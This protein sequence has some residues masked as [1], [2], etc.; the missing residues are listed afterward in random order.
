MIGIDII[1][2]KRIKKLIK[3]RKFIER[4]FSKEEIEYCENKKNKEQHYSAR[5][6]AKEA[7]WKALA[8]KYSVPLKNIVIKNIQNGK[9]EVFFN[10]KKLKKLKI[11]VSLSHTKEYAVA[12]AICF[13]TPPNAGLGRLGNKK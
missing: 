1:E 5:F 11:E 6:A 7:I 2:T 9:P 3:N 8:G 12:V 10:D 4:I 13:P